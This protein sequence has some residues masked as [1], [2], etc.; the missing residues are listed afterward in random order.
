MDGGGRPLRHPSLADKS[1]SDKILRPKHPSVVNRNW[2]TRTLHHGRV[3][4]PTLKSGF[5][6]H[7]TTTDL[8][9]TS[10]FV[11]EWRHS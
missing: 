3:V 4:S 11:T 7:A 9:A 8:R 2:V 5:R 1:D 6:S 10:T